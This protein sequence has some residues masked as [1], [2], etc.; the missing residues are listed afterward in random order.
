MSDTDFTQ[1]WELSGLS[2]YV[3]IDLETTGLDPDKD[4]IIELGAVR[5]RN[6]FGVERFER[7]VNPMRPLPS[8]ITELTGIS[9]KDLENA[10]PLE[11]LAPDFIRFVGSSPI[12]GQNIA[13]DL[14]F[15]SV[16]DS[17]LHH[18]VRSRTIPLAHD[19]GLT[20]RFI[21]P[22]F[23]GYG[24]ANLSRRFKTAVKSNHRAAKDAE[25]TGQLFAILLEKLCAVP[26]NEISTGFR[27]VEGT[28][29]PLANTL[30]SVRNALDAGLKPAA[31][32]PDPLAG[33]VSGRN[34]IYTVEGDKRPETPA[35]EKQLEQL[36]SNIDRFKEVMPGYQLRREQIGM[37]AR[38]AKAFA[39]KKILVVEAGTGVGKSMGYLIPAL[40]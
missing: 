39:D 17:T 6:G 35:S 37:A 27:F 13:F 30:R 25:A 29:S 19:T 2:D 1:F 36:L 7:L 15:L 14:G 32:V 22:C 16:A 18:F 31:P 9:D 12:V 10:L 21:F 5:F 20:A 28:A 23:D 11:E 4:D 33:P 40:L 3:A 24:L 34:N 8:F 38:A 26:L